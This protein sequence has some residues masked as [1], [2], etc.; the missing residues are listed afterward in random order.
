MGYFN[1][2]AIDIENQIKTDYRAGEIDE[3]EDDPEEVLG[4]GGEPVG[5]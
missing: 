2:I 3:L 5:K 4:D 1:D